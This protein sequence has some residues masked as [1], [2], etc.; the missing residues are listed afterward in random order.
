MPTAA[1]RADPD[2]VSQTILDYNTADVP[3]VA[4]TYSEVLGLDPVAF[5]DD[6]HDYTLLVDDKHIAIGVVDYTTRPPP[7]PRRRLD[8]VLR[9][10]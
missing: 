8:P 2:V 4:A 9:R 1:L 7:D 6:E 5:V 3:A 10:P